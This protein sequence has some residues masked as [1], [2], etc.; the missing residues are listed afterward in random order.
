[1]KENFL[2]HRRGVDSCRKFQP[3]LR[4]AL[5]ALFGASRS[6]RMFCVQVILYEALVMVARAACTDEG[7]TE[8]ALER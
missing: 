6:T 5:L 1:M 3:L 8:V 4:Q 7:E 2:L